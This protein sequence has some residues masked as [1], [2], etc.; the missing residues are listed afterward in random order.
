MS[1]DFP[2]RRDDA[3]VVRKIV[4]RKGRHMVPIFVALCDMWMSHWSQCN[5][6]CIVFPI[7]KAQTLSVA[8]RLSVAFMPLRAVP[9]GE[10]PLVR[11]HLES[12]TTRWCQRG[13]PAREDMDWATMMLFFNH[14]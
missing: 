7:S 11:L 13:L 5:S 4:G 9:L 14:L 8:A 6:I 12:L 1:R 10:Q 2:T 3:S